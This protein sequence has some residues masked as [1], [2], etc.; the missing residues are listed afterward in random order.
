MKELTGNSVVEADYVINDT[1]GDVTVSWNA[2]ST[3][4]AGSYRITILG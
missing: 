4:T 1:T 2:A 3:V